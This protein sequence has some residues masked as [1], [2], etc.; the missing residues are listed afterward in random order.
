LGTDCGR[1]LPAF[2]SCRHRSRCMCQRP[3]RKR[4][5][6]CWRRRSRAHVRAPIFPSTRWKTRN[7]KI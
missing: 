7:R 6:A 5:A 1:D 2:T 3:W 4:A